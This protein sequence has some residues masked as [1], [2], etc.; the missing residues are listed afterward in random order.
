MEN[1]KRK[2]GIAAAILIGIVAVAQM[3]KPTPSPAIVDTPSRSQA[4]LDRMKFVQTTIA[5]RGYICQD[6]TNILFVG[7]GYIVDCSAAGTQHR[8]NVENHGGLWYVTPG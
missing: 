4:E 1:I 2:L 6:V 8:F 7:V 5:D 3:G